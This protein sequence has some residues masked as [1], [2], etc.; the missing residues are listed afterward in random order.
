VIER[1]PAPP[2]QRIRGPEVAATTPIAPAAFTA[3]AL[4]WSLAATGPGASTSADAGAA[5]RRSALPTAVLLRVS[6]AEQRLAGGSTTGWSSY[7]AC[8]W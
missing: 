5:D 7:G 8:L 3:F 2:D 4:A 6:T 1:T